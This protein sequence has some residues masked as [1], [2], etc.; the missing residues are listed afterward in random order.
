M[1]DTDTLS[2]TTKRSTASS[3]P[4]RLVWLLSFLAL[5][6]T[7]VMVIVVWWTMID[8]RTERE[9]MES[10]TNELSAMRSMVDSRLEK[11]K[12]LVSALLESDKSPDKP[13]NKELLALADAYRK[14]A[15]NSG[16]DPH[17]DRLDKSIH[18]F[19]QLRSLCRQWA[20]QHNRTLARFPAM[21][22]EVETMLRQMDEAVS[23]SSGKKR[24]EWAVK[25]REFRKASSPQQSLR[26]AGS[27]I[28]DMANFSDLTST[29]RDIYDLNL[30]YDRLLNEDSM[31][32]IIY[33]KD[34][35]I[36]TV[37][38]RLQFETDSGPS[39]SNGLS[40]KL[41]QSFTAVLFGKGFRI[42]SDH[43]TILSGSGENL[44]QLC[45]NRIREKNQKEQ[46]RNDLLRLSSAIHE[47]I[48]LIADQTDVSLQQEASSLESAIKRA[49]HIIL[50]VGLATATIF[51]AISY[52]IIL[53]IKGQIK[54]I[55]DTNIM[56]DKRTRALSLSEEALRQSEERLQYLSSNLLTAQEN[57]RRRIA[58]ELHDELGQSM[59]AL[60]LQ[61]GSVER[62]LTGTSLENLGEEC[63]DIRQYIN[64]IIENM[65][66]LSK[67]LSP[68]V[69]DDLGLEA[70]IE[71]LV[72][73]FAK[74]HKMHYI[75]D[76]PDINPF[77]S[78][79]SQRLIYRIIQEALTNIG[80]HAQ[81][82]NI[83]IFAEKK[84]KSVV[85][86]IHDDGRGF[87]LEKI[88]NK[89]S[90]E[91]GMG[92]TTMAERVRIL[93][94]SIDFRSGP[95]RGTTITFTAP[96]YPGGQDNL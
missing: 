9:R 24:L 58:H 76:L 32:H 6:T 56:L 78:Q 73:N 61:I 19:Y 34:N 40:P 69:I 10:R 31:E 22:Q 71:Y 46:L 59:A 67:D 18:D 65:R 41:L 43:Q 62:R 47:N 14:A 2:N 84:E 92:L 44:F 66:R 95:G 23:R 81:A 26:L 89:K 80:K 87:D 90:T 28:D 60:K 7:I 86:M 5:Y 1:L 70:A 85:F 20:E 64:E 15:A 82:S 79:E 49:L 33:L 54:A 93:G 51:M 36:R 8:V 37:L 12:W 21:R 94:G 91:K 75:L 30:L 17:F 57:E 77:F 52:K 13:E 83:A 42:D 96:M 16:L 53:E 39:S 68:A 55:E 48:Q 4:T 35:N 74:L 45:L 72:G 88:I 11:E 3:Y 25:T 63:R 29:L 38:T 27:I 50:I